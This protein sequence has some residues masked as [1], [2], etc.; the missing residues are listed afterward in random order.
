[1]DGGDEV[2]E[3]LTSLPFTPSL[4]SC[5]SYSTPLLQQHSMLPA[6]LH[7][8]MTPSGD[9]I[10]LTIANSHGQIVPPQNTYSCESIGFMKVPGDKRAAA[11][12]FWFSERGWS[13]LTIYK[14]DGKC[15]FDLGGKATP[16]VTYQELL[17]AENE[18]IFA[19]KM[20]IK[21]DYMQAA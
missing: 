4:L 1:M 17:L 11:Y 15:F 5:L 9:L 21:D 8:G 3:N 14:H 13:G 16:D 19:I 10:H 20:D 6:T 2:S 18:T 7:F 12:K